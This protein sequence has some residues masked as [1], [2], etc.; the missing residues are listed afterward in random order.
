MYS[1]DR[2]TVDVYLNLEEG[3]KYYFRNITFEGNYLHPDSMLADVLG[4]RRGDV[5]SGETIQKRVNQSPGND[6]SSLY[7]DDG[8]LYFN[9]DPQE[10][11]VEG[12]S[13]DVNFNIFEG[14]QFT[15]NKIIIKGNTKTSDHVVLREILTLPGQKFSKTL[16]VQTQQELSRLGYFDPEKI[17]INPIPHNDYTVDIV[18]GLEEKPSDQIELSGGWGGYIGFI[19]TLGVVFNNFSVRNIGN[20]NAWRPLPSGDGQRLQIRFQANGRQFQNYS[21]TFT[22]PWLG[23][24]KP[25]SFSIGFNRQVYRLPDYT[26]MSANNPYYNPYSY[27]GYGY[28]GY[29]QG[30]Y[31]GFS[32]RLSFRGYFNT[33]GINVS[34]G[35]RLRRPDN[36]FSLNAMLSYQ[37]YEFDQYP[38]LR[39]ENF[40]SGKANNLSLIT[41]LSRYDLDNPQYTRR[42]SSIS[43]SGTLTPPYSLFRGKDWSPSTPQDKYRFLEFHK[44]MFDLSWFVP[45]TSKLVFHTR[46][47][48][49]FL[50]NYR[51]N[52][53]IIPLERFV[54]GGSG[55][56]GQGQFAI[57]QDIIGLRGY[58]DRDVLDD[59]AHVAG[60]SGGVVYNK[61]VME[62]RYPISLNPSATVFVLGFMEA[63]N[64]WASYQEFNP[65]NLKRSVGAG[66]RIF[67]PAFGM[68]GIDYAF[69]LDKNIGINGGV[70]LPGKGQFH[71]TIGQ[72]I[73]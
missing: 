31:G 71:F 51:R 54:L 72:Q 69:G 3:R 57:A 34:F 12:D 60:L 18:Y 7:M 29:G 66:A 38:L 23:G 4:I 32:G 45:I 35:K 55:L 73:R 5:Y 6:L 62:I 67:M 27:G 70:Q 59:R 43:L 37:L 26:A 30:N 48:M 13:I 50:G 53:G 24:R 64:N 17:D 44:W 20:K 14:K 1:H 41:T 36:R 28:G 42:G 33:T 9:A 16:V 25:N 19:G 21:F 58:N 52:L 49:G 65:F 22:E 39:V 63:G 10:I 46:A 8:Y 11:R 61:Y 2:S 15:I 40:N 47:H 68:I 56:S